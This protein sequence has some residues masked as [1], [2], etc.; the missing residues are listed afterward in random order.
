MLAGVARATKPEG[1]HS[2]SPLALFISVVSPPPP[3]SP[4]HIGVQ[5]ERESNP[6]LL[7]L[8]IKSGSLH[9]CSASHDAGIGVFC[10][11][12]IV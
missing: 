8:Q 5:K 1:H 3:F 2:D 4:H 9:H 12:S 7:I 10:A 6:S 11:F